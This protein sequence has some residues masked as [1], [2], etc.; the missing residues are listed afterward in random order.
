MPFRSLAPRGGRL[1]NEER[2][3]ADCW[4][5]GLWDEKFGGEK[6]DRFGPHVDR[7]QR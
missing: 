7:I 4:E 5:N 3:F 1:R 2:N 6:L